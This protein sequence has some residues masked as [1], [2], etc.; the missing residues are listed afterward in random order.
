MPSFC[1]A[2]WLSASQELSWARL[3]FRGV[4]E[5]DPM[6]TAVDENVRNFYPNLGDLVTWL[7]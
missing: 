3:R 2:S 5:G 4:E 1:Q 6:M 7:L